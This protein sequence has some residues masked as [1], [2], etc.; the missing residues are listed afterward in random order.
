MAGS[1]FLYN[2]C[3]RLI[4]NIRLKI[5]LSILSIIALFGMFSFLKHIVADNKYELVI[6]LFS[7]FISGALAGVMRRFLIKKED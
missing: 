7:A 4:L 6:I 5:V 2:Y 1:L 3:N